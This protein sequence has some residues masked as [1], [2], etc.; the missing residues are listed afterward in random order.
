M[1]ATAAVVHESMFGNTA[2]IA[3]AV[4]DGLRRAEMQVTESDVS[5]IE[6]GWLPACDLIVVGAPTHAFSLSRPATRA[7]AIRQGAP[8]GGPGPTGLREWISQLPDVPRKD[9]QPD[10]SPRIAV[11]DTR[12]SKVRRVPASASRRAATMLRRKG[13]RLV[14]T[15]T[16]FLVE[17]VPGPLV[18]G[19]LDRA[20][21]WGRA[22]VDSL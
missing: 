1:S 10:Q 4:A 17:D 22:V 8:A 11:F 2:A 6:P 3:G 9:R 20:K 5:E 21:A 12:A 7:D 19:E 13:Y 15:P 16:G 14:G 18:A